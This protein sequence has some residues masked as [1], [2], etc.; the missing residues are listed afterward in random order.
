MDS[1]DM[2]GI[3]LGVGLKLTGST[4]EVIWLHENYQSDQSLLKD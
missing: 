1:E 2:I 3:S 4:G